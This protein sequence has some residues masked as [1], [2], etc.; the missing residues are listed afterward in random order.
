MTFKWRYILYLVLIIIAAGLAYA[1]RATYTPYGRL[2][3]R[4]A[5]SLRLLS[6]P[7]TIRPDPDSDLA[8]SMPINSFYMISLILPKEKVSK[9]KDVTIPGKGVEVPAR[10]YWPEGADATQSPLPLIVYFHGGGFTTGSVD[11]FDHLTRSLSNAAHAIVVSVDYRLAPAHPY[12][13]ALDDC[14]AALEWGAQNARSLGGDP[15]KLAVGGDSAGGNL[16]AVMALKARDA[17]GPKIAAQIMYYPATDLTDTPYDSK[18]HFADGYGL[19]KEAETAFHQAYVGK[20]ENT[21]DRYIS[22]LYAPS[23][24]GLPPALVIIG[25]FDPLHDS[26]QAYVKRLLQAGVPVTFHQYPEMVHGFMSIPLFSQRRKAL[27][28]TSAFLTNVFGSP[29]AG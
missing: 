4:A 18:T 22:P 29:D 17:G 1:Y 10:V 8:F 16:A 13:A 6:I 5:L 25:G 27:N 7:M 28:D 20:V 11:I 19:S 3:Y 12:P 9:V 26:A 14:Y 2:D 23:L 21:K 24:D 15:A